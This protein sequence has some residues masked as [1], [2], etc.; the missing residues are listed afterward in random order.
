MRFCSTENLNT[1]Q[2]AR[3]PSTCKQVGKRC[4]LSAAAQVLHTPHPV[5]LFYGNDV[6]PEQASGGPYPVV[7]IWPPWRHP[8]SRNRHVPRGS[9]ILRMLNKE[10]WVWHA[11]LTMLGCQR[12]ADNVSLPLREQ[13]APEVMR[14]IVPEGMASLV[15]IVVLANFTRLADSMRTVTIHRIMERN[16]YPGV[17]LRCTA[18][19]GPLQT[20]SCGLVVGGPPLIDLPCVGFGPQDYPSSLSDHLLCH[21]SPALR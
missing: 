14:S 20:L 18:I 10:A 21:A 9:K 6:P 19:G 13:Y 7:W 2:I 11:M 16:K 5:I 17:M 8:S 12:D 15:E 3:H 4:I 1:K